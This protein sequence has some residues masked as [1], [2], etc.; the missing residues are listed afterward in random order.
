[1]VG[2]SSLVGGLAWWVGLA[3]WLGG[4]AWRDAVARLRGLLVGFQVGEPRSHADRP[5]GRFLVGS[6]RGSDRCLH[7][8]R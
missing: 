2:W 5:R 3:G 4:P 7:A 1:M 6:S 8:R